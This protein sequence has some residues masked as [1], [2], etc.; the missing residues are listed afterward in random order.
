[1]APVEPANTRKACVGFW[2]AMRAGQWHR[3]RGED[4]VIDVHFHEAIQ[5]GVVMLE[6][7]VR[8]VGPDELGVMA[9]DS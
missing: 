8:D 2:M 1:V 3:G 6:E 9:M 4:D 7:H 5:H